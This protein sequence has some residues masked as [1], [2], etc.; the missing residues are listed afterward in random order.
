[1]F[2]PNQWVILALCFLL[3]LILGMALMANNKWK[4]RYRDERARSEALERDNQR[5]EKQSAEMDSL[6]HA[7]ARDEGRRRTD[8]PGP[9]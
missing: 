9:L 5:L 8:V 3:G 7:A 2:S 1:L 6:R 4:R